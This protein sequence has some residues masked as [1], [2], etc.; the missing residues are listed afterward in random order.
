MQGLEEATHGNSIGWRAGWA[1]IEVVLLDVNAIDSDAAQGN[2][3]VRNVRDGAGGTGV[4][5]NSG[6]V[7]RV[8]DLAVLEDNAIDSIVRLATYGANGQTMAAFAVVSKARCVNCARDRL[9]NTY[10]CN[11]F[12]SPRRLSR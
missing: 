11:T 8:Q 6:T 9:S 2:V 1:T 3:L 5:L 7:L 12:R 4:S 10:H